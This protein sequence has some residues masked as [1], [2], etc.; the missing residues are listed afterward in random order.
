M[1]DVC[2]Y[3]TYS[4]KVGAIVVIV[5]V[6]VVSAFDLTQLKLHMQTYKNFTYLCK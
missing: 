2:P 4:N 6:Y 1:A 3:P 5:D